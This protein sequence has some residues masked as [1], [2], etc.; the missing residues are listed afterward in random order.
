[1]ANEELR[2]VLPAAMATEG[3]PVSP[4]GGVGS[5]GAGSPKTGHIVVTRCGPNPKSAWWGSKVE[6]QHG[7]KALTIA[8]IVDK[9]QHAQN[10]YEKAAWKTDTM[11][12]VC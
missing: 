6:E 7:P 8:K 11:R 5:P 1:M 12:R 3:P 4:R 2:G 9:S 10:L